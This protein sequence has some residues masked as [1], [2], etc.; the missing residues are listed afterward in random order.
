MKWK[1]YTESSIENNSII[2][3][4]GISVTGISGVQERLLSGYSCEPYYS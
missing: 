3:V 2:N 1:Y 4:A